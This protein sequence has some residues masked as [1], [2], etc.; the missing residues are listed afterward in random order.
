MIFKAA[1]ATT[2]Q[3]RI[4]GNGKNLIFTK[5][6]YRLCM[7]IKEAE[8]MGMKNQFSHTLFK[9]QPQNKPHLW[10]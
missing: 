5:Q 1:V 4:T 7:Y 6:T 2:I 3:Y 8:L 9:I 10:M